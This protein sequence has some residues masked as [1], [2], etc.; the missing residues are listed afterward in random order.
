MPS[1]VIVKS[2]KDG[3]GKVQFLVNKEK[4]RHRNFC[5][6]TI[7]YWSSRD[8]FPKNMDGTRPFCRLERGEFAVRMHDCSIQILEVREYR[9]IFLDGEEI[10]TD[11]PVEGFHTSILSETGEAILQFLMDRI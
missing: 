1:R 3:E 6:L 9:V 2:W 7:R 4:G 5:Q 10:K 8:P 11:Y